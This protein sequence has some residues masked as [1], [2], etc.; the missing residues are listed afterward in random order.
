MS[1]KLFSKEKKKRNDIIFIVSLLVAVSLIGLVYYFCRAEGSY[2][3]VEVD[4]KTF[5]EYSLASEIELD[6]PSK[7]GF[8]RLVI[9]DGRAS[10][11]EAS[12][13][14]G[15]CSAHRPISKVG[16]SIVCLPNKVVVRVTGASEDQPDIAA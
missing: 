2:I 3:L 13:P 14:D 4:G 6:I 8:N 16:E 9:K 15:I 11:I 1:F 7:N 10:V 12:C 5:G